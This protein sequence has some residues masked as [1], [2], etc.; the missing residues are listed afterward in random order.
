MAADRLERHARARGIAD[1]AGQPSVAQPADATPRGLG[2]PAD[3]DRKAAS[4]RRLWLHRHRRDGIA[5]PRGVH[6][7]LAPPRAEQR[8][9]LVHA[10]AARSEIL[11][12]RLVLG[13]LP[14]HTDAE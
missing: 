5:R 10:G 13:L 4:L 9:R 14:A 8:D 3:P 2:H 7:R 11:A 1:A 6:L 12:E